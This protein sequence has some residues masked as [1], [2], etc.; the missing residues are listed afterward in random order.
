ML[1]KM[2]K[3][4]LP[5]KIDK[6][7]GTMELQRICD[8]LGVNFERAREYGHNEKPNLNEYENCKRIIIRTAESRAEY[9]GKYACKH[10]RDV[11]E[12]IDF[13]HRHDFW[14]RPYIVQRV[15]RREDIAQYGTITLAK[16][17]DGKAWTGYDFSNDAS[18]AQDGVFWLLSIKKS[19]RFKGGRL[20]PA[21][22]KSLN[23]AIGDKNIGRLA[24]HIIGR[25][26]QNISGA[27]GW[28]AEIRYVKYKGKSRPYFYDMVTA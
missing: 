19:F 13:Q 12:D 2:A 26:P 21:D 7:S 14:N 16:S 6:I 20:S 27:L 28:F 9:G 3:T 24:E 1:A 15:G 23:S 25:A 11:L 22:S 5:L 10:P 8:A 17:R 18:K 4:K